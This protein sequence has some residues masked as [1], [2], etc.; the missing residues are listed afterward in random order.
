ML[1]KT[2]KIVLLSLL[3]IA[4]LSPMLQLNSCD[5]FPVSSD[6]IEAD[7]T[8]CLCSLGMVLVLV[9]SS[10]LKIMPLLARSVVPFP[11]QLRPEKNS[12]QVTDYYPRC[13]P[14]SLLSPLRI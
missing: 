8:Y 10:M 2:C 14:I 4:V 12:F 9:V 13:I 5:R 11:F 7:V 1:H 6:D 3:L